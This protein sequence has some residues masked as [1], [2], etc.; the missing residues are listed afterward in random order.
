MEV[1]GRDDK[2]Q[3]SK[4]IPQFCISFLGAEGTGHSVCCSGKQSF[5][6]NSSFCGNG[7]FPFIKSKLIA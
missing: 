1:W 7:I 5:R 6:V 2:E 4:I 3:T